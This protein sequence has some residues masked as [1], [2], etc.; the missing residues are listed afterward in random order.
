MGIMLA[1]VFVVKMINIMKIV[2]AKITI[3]QII[4]CK[5]LTMFVKSVNKTITSAINTVVN[6]ITIIMVYSVCS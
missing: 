2:N 5:L 4:V 3:E 6:K 1:M